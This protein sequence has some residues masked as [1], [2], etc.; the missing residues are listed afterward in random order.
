MSAHGTEL[1]LKMRDMIQTSDLLE[2]SSST[3]IGWSIRAFTGEAV[4]HSSVGLVLEYK[5]LGHDRRFLVE[6]LEYGVQLSLLSRRLER[7][8]GKVYL[9]RLKPEHD[10]LRK[11]IAAYTLLQIGK[12]YDYGSLFKNALGKVS[13]DARQ[14]FCS[15]LVFM[16]LQSVGL[17]DGKKSPRPG[18][19][20]KYGVFE[21]PLRIF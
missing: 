5:D 18:Q 17:V 16:A 15:E 20:G 12:G 6:A 14:F 4:N 1:Y 2:F 10:S 7:F 9:N 21:E 3:I 8:K 19:F 13:A 11:K